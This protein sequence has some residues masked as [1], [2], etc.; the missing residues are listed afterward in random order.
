MILHLKKSFNFLLPNFQSSITQY[1]YEK[2]FHFTFIRFHQF[3]LQKKKK[4][5]IKHDSQFS[6][7]K[8]IFTREK[9]TCQLFPSIETFLIAPFH[10]LSSNFETW[11]KILSYD[12]IKKE[13][14]NNKLINDLLIEILNKKKINNL[15][16]KRLEIKEK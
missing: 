1:T 12:T 7:I 10:S 16:K 8:K 3:P 14:R 15:K 6:I 2:N 11:I 5:F 9:K 13:W 4:V